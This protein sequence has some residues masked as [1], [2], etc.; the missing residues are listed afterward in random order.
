MTTSHTISVMVHWPRTKQ[1][2]GEQPRPF[3][4]P[5]QHPLGAKVI[6]ADY[7]PDYL[8]HPA[9]VPDPYA[10]HNG[11]SVP[12]VP[13]TT[14]LVPKLS[15]R[16]EDLS[17]LGISIFLKHIKPYEDMRYAVIEV[18]QC[19]YTMQT[20]PRKCVDTACS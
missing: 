1:S 6:G 19:L 2:Q 15:L 13:P 3:M 8:P 18:L 16:I 12:H 10:R 20:Q 7:R 14:W 17:N 9:A 11:Q 4:L 5:P